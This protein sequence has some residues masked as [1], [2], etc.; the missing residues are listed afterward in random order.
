MFISTG[1]PKIKTTKIV[2]PTLNLGFQSNLFY[3]HVI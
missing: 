3:F 2:C 1:V